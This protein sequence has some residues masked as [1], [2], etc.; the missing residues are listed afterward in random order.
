[1]FPLYLQSLG[2]TGTAVE[3][4]VAEG[5]YSRIFLDLWPGQY[6][7]V[8]RWAHIDG[9][10]DIMNGPDAEHEGRYRQAMEVAARYADRCRVLRM[11]SAE[12]A[13]Q[14]ADKSLDFVYIDGDHSVQGCTRDILAWAPKVK[15]G[16]ILAGHD[17]Y[18]SHP[19]GVRTAVNRCCNG[20]C[21]ITHDPCPSWWVH[22]P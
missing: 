4:G 20:P 17:Y 8:D 12:A 22:M 6:V 13:G 2:H 5:N 21:G 9:Y 3:I 10:D 19:F 7:M 1:M 14:F 15:S 11:D 16:G 18:D